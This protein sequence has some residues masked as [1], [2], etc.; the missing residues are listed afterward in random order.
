MLQIAGTQKYIH[1]LLKFSRKYTI[2]K[3]RYN[4]SMWINK[5][6]YLVIN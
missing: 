1:N 5:P 4:T 3:I 6:F 2:S